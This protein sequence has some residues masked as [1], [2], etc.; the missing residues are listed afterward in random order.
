MNLRRHRGTIA[1]LFL[2]A[3]LFAL[4]VGIANACLIEPASASR[5]VGMA[6][7][8]GH[9]SDA[10]AASGCLKFCSDDT[11]VF[12]RL[13]LTQDPPFGPPVLVELL[14]PRL[15]PAAAAAVTAAHRAHPPPDVP[16][17]LRTLRLA[18]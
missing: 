17:L 12:T 6:M 5:V 14:G 9:D 3:W 11:P 4:F 8:A 1:T 16:L 13:E 2:G 15:L 18:L 10:D 7:D